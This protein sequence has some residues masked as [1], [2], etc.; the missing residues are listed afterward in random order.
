[1]KKVL[2]L[3]LLPGAFFASD[4][5]LALADG[6]DTPQKV[7]VK[8]NYFFCKQARHVHHRQPNPVHSTRHGCSPRVRVIEVIDIPVP[9]P[10]PMTDDSE[11]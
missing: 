7:E 1:M 11:D 6:A 5:A 4:L 2:A 9:N 10:D 3:L 8:E